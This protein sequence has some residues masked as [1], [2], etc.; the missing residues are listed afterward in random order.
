[1]P[2]LAPGKEEP[3]AGVQAEDRGVWE[4]SSAGNA[5]EM[6]ADSNCLAVKLA[7]S[8]CDCIS[9]CIASRLRQVIILF[10]YSAL[11]ASYLGTTSSFRILI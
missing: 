4:S 9:R 3:L 6:L 1:M 8:I 11:I 2:S 5:L 10:D 7:T